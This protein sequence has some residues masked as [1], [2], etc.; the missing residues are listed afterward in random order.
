MPAVSIIVPN[1]NHAG[2][3]DKRMSSIFNQTFRDYE[4]ILL[5]DCSTDGSKQLLDEYSR[6]SRVT[7]YEVNQSN[8][9]SPFSQWGKGIKMATGKYIWIAESDDFAD[10]DFLMETVKIMEG[11]P[12]MAVCYCA[13]QC[14]DESGEPLNLDYNLWETDK[15]TGRIGTVAVHD[16]NEFIKKNLYW[17]CYIYNASAALIRN[18]ALKEGIL[19]ESKKM[20]NAG[21]WLFWTKLVKDYK[22]GEY[23]KQLNF[24]RRHS[25]S[26]TIV[27]QR[28]GS[29][30]FENIKVMA[31]IERNHRIGFYRKL[32]RH[33]T[34]IENI[35]HSS[36]PQELKD[37]ILETF[38][39]ETGATIRAYR[40]ERLHHAL[41]K[42]LPGLISRGTDRL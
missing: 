20:R 12:E 29:I 4:I 33:G 19:E 13:S 42:L 8:S 36:M 38:Y 25:A 34:Y 1:Y 27:G 7:R 40:A 39:K 15:K 28:Q 5:D 3:L 23:Y 24:M 22:V 16:G 18:E 2:F 6:D 30:E 26:T 14:V 41:G 9:G 10:P 31:Y 37:K 11:E 17:S 21:D 35:R 32:I